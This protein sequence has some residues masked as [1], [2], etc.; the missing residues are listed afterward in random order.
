MKI[1]SYVFWQISLLIKL[2]L[3]KITKGKKVM[4]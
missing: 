3:G 1:M 2:R 4:C